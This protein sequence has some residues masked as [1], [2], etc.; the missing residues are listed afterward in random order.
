MG[1]GVG[2]GPR[3]SYDDDGR[4]EDGTGKKGEGGDE[5]RNTKQTQR[6]ETLGRGQERPRPSP[7]RPC[8]ASTAPREKKAPSSTTRGVSMTSRAATTRSI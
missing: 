8:G 2:R 6:S 1:R 3:P 5:T 4:G 7:T